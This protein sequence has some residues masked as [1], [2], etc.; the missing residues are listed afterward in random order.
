MAKFRF[1]NKEE[2]KALQKRAEALKPKAIG[3]VATAQGWS[4]PRPNG[5]MELLVSF[6]GLDEL[7]GDMETE[8]VE[9]VVDP[10]PVQVI[11]PPKLTPKKPGRPAKAE[12]A[13]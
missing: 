6:A 10:E 2:K 12:K 3:V 4:Q 7:L 8:V 9:Q 11:E 1:D 13:E 5:T